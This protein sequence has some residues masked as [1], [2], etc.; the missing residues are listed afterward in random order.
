MSDKTRAKNIAQRLVD[1]GVISPSLTE[2][3]LITN[4]IHKMIDDDYIPGGKRTISITNLQP[5]PT[6]NRCGVQVGNDAQSGPFYC[7]LPATLM[8]NS[9]NGI[10]FACARHESVLECLEK[11]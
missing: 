10:V 5:A 6:G 4:E 2:I 7:G 11:K 1:I 8:G 3:E 9:E